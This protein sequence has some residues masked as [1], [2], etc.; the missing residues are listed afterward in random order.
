MNKMEQLKKDL[1]LNFPLR[2]TLSWEEIAPHDCEEC[3]DI[4]DDFFDK[5]WDQIDSKTLKYHH[6]SLPFFSAKAFQYY[7]SAYILAKILDMNAAGC[8]LLEYARCPNENESNEL[9]FERRKIFTEG[10]KDVIV[11]FLEEWGKKD[12]YNQGEYKRGIEFWKK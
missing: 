3:F 2:N 5:T 8:D 4:R 7:L 9:M 1:Y 10:Q 6:D 12:S 11:K